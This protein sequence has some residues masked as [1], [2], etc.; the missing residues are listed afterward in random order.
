MPLSAVVDVARSAELEGVHGVWVTE[1]WRSAFVPLTAIAAATERVTLGTYVINAY[2]HSPFITGMSAIDLDEASNGRLVLGIGSGNRYTNLLYQ[3][4]PTERPLTK[5]R[6]YVELV[7]RFV[8]ARP[9]DIVSYEGEIHSMTGCPPQVLPVRPAI[10]VYLA[11]TFHRMIGVAGAVADGV[12]FGALHAVDYLEDVV[13]PIAAEGAVA[14]GRDPAEL[15]YAA[16][17]FL[18]ADDDREAARNAARIALCNLYAPKPHP[19]YDFLL[20]QQGYADVAD[21]IA[22]EV[23]GGHRDAAAGAIPD[24][25]LDR[26]AVTGTREECLRRI[27][28]YRGVVDELLLMN[29]G[30][31]RYSLSEEEA[32]DGA[33]TASFGGFVAMAGEIARSRGRIRRSGA[34]SWD[35]PLTAADDSYT[36]QVV[37]PAAVSAY[38]D[39]AWAE[40]CWHVVYLGE[41]WMAGIGRA[42]WQHG[43]RRTAR[44]G[45]NTGPLQLSRRVE[46]P[47]ALGDDPNRGDVGPIRVETIEPLREFRLVLDEPGLDFG[48]DLT[49][50]ARTVAAPSDRNLIERD[51]EVLTDYMNFF[52]SGLYSGVVFAD[53]EER[54]VADRAG[55][56][57]RGWGLRKHEG[58][59]RRGLHVACM[60]EFPDEALY[61][62]L[63]ETGSGRRAFTNGWA[64]G[65][66][67]V[68]DHVVEVEHDLSFDGT[69]HD[70]G[71]RARVACLRRGPRDRRHRRGAALDLHARL[72]D[73]SRPR[74]A[75]REPVRRDGSRGA[76][77]DRRRVRAGLPLR[78]GRRRRARIRRDG[79]RLAREI[80]AG[81][82]GDVTDS[83]SA[84]GPDAIE[85][86]RNIRGE[87]AS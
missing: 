75:R 65:A 43:G 36:H 18:S 37:A 8:R 86:G 46:E 39:P 56:R 78:G 69:L 47:F 24:E 34:V 22:R 80:H 73:R 44:A 79:P 58:A 3:G 16:A 6:E 14:A 9:G 27:A 82:R 64:L 61:I 66:D 51:G 84:Q 17:M 42:V 77:A 31:L 11:A 63:Y 30:G 68:R 45:V 20:R 1:A 40:R 41:G 25:L 62:L 5:M 70:R 13:K 19:H 35:A 54:R 60:C 72:H 12:A 76:V 87:P 29:V 85:G 15:R 23:E 59:A 7:R 32:A 52:Q 49:Y 81:H 38:A 10:P 21:T 74:R 48:F 4:I 50:R 71:R 67:G 55:F 28:D 2:G 83:G 26:L 57:D 53:G 33:L